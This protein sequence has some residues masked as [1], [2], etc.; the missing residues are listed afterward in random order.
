VVSKAVPLRKRPSVDFFILNAQL[1]QNLLVYGCTSCYNSR[2]SGTDGEV[3]RRINSQND[4]DERNS[5]LH[6]PSGEEDVMPLKDGSCSELPET[7]WWDIHDSNG[8][9][10][11]CPGGIRANFE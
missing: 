6:H 4:D 8:C 11:A 5:L 7:T 3:I 1:Y 10:W 9:L 2:G